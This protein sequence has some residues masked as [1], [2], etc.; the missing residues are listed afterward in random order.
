[1]I[2]S[3]KCIIGIDAGASKTEAIAFLIEGSIIE[4]KSKLSHLQNTGRGVL[5]TYPPI[6][7]NILGEKKT[8]QILSSIIGSEIK[9]SK[10]K[11]ISIVIGIAGARNKKDRNEIEKQLIKIFKI[12]NIK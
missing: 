2:S 11:N 9:K 6:N 12:K 5:Q 10:T 1:M 3:N 4:F 8:I 7:Y